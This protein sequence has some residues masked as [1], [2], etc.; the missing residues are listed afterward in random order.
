MAVNNQQDYYKDFRNKKEKAL[1]Y[2]LDI[3]KFE[4][5]LYWKRATYFW[6]FIAATMTG[7]F[8]TN[9]SNLI[10]KGD[11]VFLLAC[12][13]L[14]FSLGWFYVNKGS[15]YWQ[16]NWENHVNMLEDN[17]I[18]PLYTV[19]LSRQEDK[20]IK[21]KIKRLLFGPAPF[22]VSKI[23]QL[24]S[25]FIVIIWCILLYKSLY[26]KIGAP[27]NWYQVV[28][29]F[30]TIIVCLALNFLCRSDKGKYELSA[31]KRKIEIV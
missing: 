23:N 1:K 6:A 7:Y 13:G 15:K 11:Y 30:I 2:A 24:I 25:L 10:N 8:A 21:D 17:V 22:S 31:V 4:I 12:V 27:V 16:E 18:G 20:K 9:S 28:I 14:V 29:L 3:R 5:E 26:F 19:V